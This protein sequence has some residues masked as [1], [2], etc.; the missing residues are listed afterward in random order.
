[1]AATPLQ[2]TC[3]R[4]LSWHDGFERKMGQLWRIA[5]QLKDPSQPLI[6]FTS[7]NVRKQYYGR[8]DARG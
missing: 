3:Q 2:T 7:T 6:W 5:A 4:R 1:M 8:A